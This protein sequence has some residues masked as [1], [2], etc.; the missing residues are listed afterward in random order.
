MNSKTVIDETIEEIL[1][2]KFLP[3]G[4]LTYPPENAS[5]DNQYSLSTYTGELSYKE[6]SGIYY[7]DYFIGRAFEFLSTGALYAIKGK[8]EKQLVHYMSTAKSLS[9]LLIKTI[10]NTLCSCQNYHKP[11]KGLPA[12]YTTRKMATIVPLV[13]SS[14]ILE[15]WKTLKEIAQHL[16]DSLNAKT[17]SIGRGE[18]TAY[19]E[20]FTIKLLGQ[21]FKIE[22]DER[23][24]FHPNKNNFQLYQQI[25]DNWDTDDMT[26]LDK[27]IYILADLHIEDAEENWDEFDYILSEELYMLFAY[28]IIVLLQVRKYANLNNSHSFSHPIMKTAF[29]KSF[30]NIKE[31]IPE[32]EPQKDIYIF[33]KTLGEKCPNV[34]IPEWLI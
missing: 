22:I 31:T 13:S 11:M 8:E 18:F 9:T 26:E 2:S 23:K 4:G 12:K 34:E 25:L 7:L 1:Q 6:S 5:K 21:V 3:T 28:E 30:F 33:L 15:D 32:A 20:W 29:M 19:I 14:A 24:P 27:M 16:I 10:S 17:C